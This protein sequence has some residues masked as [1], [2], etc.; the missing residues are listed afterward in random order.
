[1]ITSAHPNR[2]TVRV[3]S[4]VNRLKAVF[5]SYPEPLLP[6]TRAVARFLWEGLV[7]VMC[8]LS[9]RDTFS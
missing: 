7:L 8:R 2:L 6:A 1:M 3:M 5:H 9:V 4:Q